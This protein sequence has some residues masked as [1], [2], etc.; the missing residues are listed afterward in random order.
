MADLTGFQNLK[1]EYKLIEDSKARFYPSGEQGCDEATFL[2]NNPNSSKSIFEALDLNKDGYVTEREYG[3]T[4]GMD[5][6]GDGIVTDKERNDACMEQ[7][8]YFARRNVDKYFKVDRNRD[9]SISNVEDEAWRRMNKEDNTLDGGLSN[10]ELAE[11]YNMKEE[12]LKDENVQGWLDGT[13]E[14]LNQIA[15]LKY[16]VE[17]SQKQIIEIKKEFIKQLNTWLLREGDNE[18]SPLYVQANINA[19]TRLVTDEETI[20]CCGGNIDKPPMASQPVLDENG[21]VQATGCARIFRTMAREGSVNNA[22]EMKNRL[23]W[24]MFLTKSDEEQASM[25]KEEYAKHQQ[26]WFNMRSMK[27]QDFRELLKPENQA[28]RK[29]FEKNACMTVKQIVMYIDI[30]E[31]VTGKPWDSDDW[32]V[33]ADMFYEIALKANGTYGDETRLEGKTRADIPKNRQALLRF[34]EQRGWLYPQ[35]ESPV[36]ENTAPNTNN[37]DVSKI[38][39][40]EPNV[41]NN[42]AL[43]AETGIIKRETLS[44]EELQKMIEAKF[45]ELSKEYNT[46]D[47]NI[48]ITANE[49]GDLSWQ[50]EKRS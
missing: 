13:I 47:Y 27:A 25:T 28:Q 32:E 29:E 36:S 22:D 40:T 39:A 44:Q 6:D 10:R 48:Q 16:G 31:S 3:Y 19:Y 4:L 46:N 50:I 17:L 23:A 33:D 38:E 5:K 41:N 7:L 9:G 43:N 35:F 1:M 42:G 14:E 24:A 18:D 37:N 2:R 20:S 11:K 15:K 8:L 30:V 34:L 49:Y 45:E 21:E 12:L 26:D